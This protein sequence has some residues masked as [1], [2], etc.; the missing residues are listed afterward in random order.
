MTSDQSSAK[1]EL[2]FSK[3]RCSRPLG[4][5]ATLQIERQCSS[6]TRSPQSSDLSSFPGLLVLRGILPYGKLVCGEAEG[7]GSLRRAKARRSDGIVGPQDV[8]RLF[9]LPSLVELVASS[10]AFF[11]VQAALRLSGGARHVFAKPAPSGKDDRN[12]RDTFL[13]TNTIKGTSERA[14]IWR[15]SKSKEI[16]IT[17]IL[18]QSV[19]TTALLAG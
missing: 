11:Q 5:Y 15:R 6:E 4:N 3:Q 9:S 1:A 12:F 2:A 14:R 8:W 10:T 7:H 17:P 19:W 18:T 16:D 13:R